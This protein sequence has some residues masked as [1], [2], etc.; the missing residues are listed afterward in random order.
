MNLFCISVMQKSGCVWA[1]FIF[2]FK[3]KVAQI[4]F[5]SPV[6]FKNELKCTGMIS[7]SV[8]KCLKPEDRIGGRRVGWWR[9]QGEKLKLLPL[10]NGGGQ[11]SRT[12]PTVESHCQI[13]PSSSQFCSQQT[14]HYFRHV[15]S[16]YGWK[17]SNLKLVGPFTV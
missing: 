12:S 4:F 11:S 16:E 9:G 14:W 5:S 17:G 8:C 2:Y 7:L 6:A 10:L 15:L 3:L 13:C 1:Y